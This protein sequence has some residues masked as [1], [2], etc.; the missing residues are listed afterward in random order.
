MVP[1]SYTHL[2]LVGRLF[3]GSHRIPLALA[4]LHSP[5]G[6]VVDAVL[7][8]ENSVSILFSFAH[9]YFHVE[10]E[11]PYDLVHFLK[12]IMP[13]K[14]TGEL[15]ISLGYHKHGKTELYLSLIHI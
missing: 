14:R 15:Y 8:D 7:L 11:R 5:E 13:R 3:S 1:V 10:V 6:I 4:L 2:Y 9:S 12:T